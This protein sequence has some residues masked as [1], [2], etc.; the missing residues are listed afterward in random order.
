MSARLAAVTAAVLVTA[1]GN[2]TIAPSPTTPTP[3][4]A[5]PSVESPGGALAG[6]LAA[7]RNQDNSQVT[8]WLAT[9]ADTTNLNE[10]LRV[11]STFGTSGVYWVVSRLSVTGVENTGA[12]RAN[13]TLSGDI[14]W[15]LGKAVN[16]PAA[17]CSVVNHVSGRPHTYA[18]VQVD[19]RW[20]A[21]IDVTASS[22]LDHNPEASPTAGAPTATPTAT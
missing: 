22:G 14:V 1:C 12:G 7:A 21:D 17:T 10:L 16:D 8:V 19:G 18:A 13:V 3:A 5:T 20:K 11:Y 6:F 15:C 9:T 2:T 4:A